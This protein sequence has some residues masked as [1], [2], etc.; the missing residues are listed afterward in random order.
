MNFNNICKEILEEKKPKPL[1]GYDYYKS[2]RKAVPK[3]GTS[4]KDKSKYN[5]REKHKKNVY[6]E[7]LDAKSHFRQI[8]DAL[9]A[10][11]LKAFEQEPILK[12]VQKAITL[13]F[14]EGYKAGTTNP[15]K[16]L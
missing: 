14:N 13:A 10:F 11:G 9:G 2:I 4:F 1:T 3:P 8:S 12:I 5:R 16:N 6:E 15:F 7:S